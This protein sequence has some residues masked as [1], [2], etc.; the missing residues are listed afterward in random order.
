MPNRRNVLYLLMIFSLLTGLFTGRQQLFNLVYLIACL[1]VLSLLW[2]RLSL[3]GV[4]LRRST[5]SRRSQVGA[6]LPRIIQHSQAGI[7]PKLWLEVVDHST[8]P[9][10]QASQVVPSLIGGREYSWDVETVCQAR[11]EYQLG[12]MT[13]ISSDPLWFFR[14][15]RRIGAVE[16]LVVYPLTVDVK[17]MSLPVGYLSGGD[18]QRRLTHQIT[19][20]ASSIRDY[21]P[22]DTMNR[23]HWR[24]TARAGSLMGQGV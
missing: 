12:P 22:G 7:L 5:R 18:A 8:L 21:V 6:H 17:Q 4:A 23:I 13:V 20:N 24:S 9:G 15:P 2:T 1:L 16:R 19:T 3:R 14:S 10:H 11:G